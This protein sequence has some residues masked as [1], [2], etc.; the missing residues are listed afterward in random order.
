MPQMQLTVHI[1]TTKT[2]STSIQKFLSTNR[3][4]LRQK[5]VLV[6]ASL[7]KVMH[8]RATLA[9]LPPDASTDLMKMFGL[10]DAESHEAFRQ[11]AV[12]DFRNDIAQAPDCREVVITSEHLH[13]RVT[14]GA[15]IQRFKDLF[16][17]DFSGVRIVVYIR[18][19]LDQIISLYSTVLRERYAGTL[20]H[21]IKTRMAPRFRPYFDVKDVITRWSALFGDANVLVRPYKA[22]PPAQGGVVAD[23]CQI[24]GFRHDDPAFSTPTDVN[25]SI[26]T[27]G[28]ELLRIL[29]QGGGLEPAQK[30]KVVAWVEQNCSG[31]GEE[32]KLAQAQSFQA[33]F[34]EG[35]DWVVQ[36]YFPDHPEYLEPRWPQG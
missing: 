14:D 9:S 33:Q 10:V 19:Q 11:M 12:T 13:S 31:K 29:N 6:P 17:Q 25:S 32:P 20:E 2:G 28:Q 15:D 22:L 36:K 35:N 26:S 18:P 8:L 16:C 3:E 5:G 21:F 34:R 30:R 27:Q 1:G 23:F 7:G 4:G 24:L